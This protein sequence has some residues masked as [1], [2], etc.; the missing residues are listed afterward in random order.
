ME[1]KPPDF[2]GAR[3]RYQKTMVEDRIEV[4]SEGKDKR[5]ALNQT[6]QPW[7]DADHTRE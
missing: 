5:T 7:T 1:P 3:P 4:G 2:L 6:S